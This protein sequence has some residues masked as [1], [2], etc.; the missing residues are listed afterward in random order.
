MRLLIVE[1]ELSIARDIEY[2]CKQLLAEKIETLDIIQTLDEAIEFLSNSEIDLL[3]LDLNLSGK[4][5]FDLLKVA[6]AGPYHTIIISAHTDQ[7][8]E[9][10]QHGVLDFVP[11]PLEKNRLSKALNR[12]LDKSKGEN[13]P[14]KYLTVRKYKEYSIL[15]VDDILYFRAANYYSEAVLRSG[16]TEILD[17]SLDRLYQ[18]LPDHFFRS[19]RSYIVD[20]HQIASFTPIIKGSCQITLR[21][22]EILPLSRARYKELREVIAAI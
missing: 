1:D 19:H 2:N 5:G 15:H 20:I 14:A 3:L 18:I 9:A 6:V 21:N 11:K 8:I 10:F 16:K 7:A 4:S 13:H 12:F 17:K 22:G